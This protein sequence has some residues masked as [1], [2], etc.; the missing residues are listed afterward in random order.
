MDTIHSRKDLVYV[1]FALLRASE[2]CGIG[3]AALLA[4]AQLFNEL[5]LKFG[6]SKKCP[7]AR[8]VS[9]HDLSALPER[10]RGLRSRAEKGRLKNGL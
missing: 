3:T 4:H 10:M 7:Q 2:P 1:R 6:T 9:G 8:Q 5:Q